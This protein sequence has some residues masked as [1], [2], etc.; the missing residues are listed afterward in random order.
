MATGSV[1]TGA[2]IRLD[3][4]Q[5]PI[6]LELVWYQWSTPNAGERN[7]IVKMK[8]RVLC[9]RRRAMPDQQRPPSPGEAVSAITI[10]TAVAIAAICDS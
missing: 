2:R 9:A 7:T 3:P 8:S 6:N 5:L 4:V 10:V 1:Q